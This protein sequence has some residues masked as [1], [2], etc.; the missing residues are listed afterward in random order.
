VSEEDLGKAFCFGNLEADTIGSVAPAGKSVDLSNI[1]TVGDLYALVSAGFAYAEILDRQFEKFSKDPQFQ[2]IFEEYRSG[3]KNYRDSKRHYPND[4]LK[5][6]VSAE[7]YE[8]LL[9][10]LGPLA[11]ENESIRIPSED[12][13]L[14]FR[15]F[16]CKVWLSE[17]FLASFD[18]DNDLTKYG[19]IMFFP[20]LLNAITSRYI[21][22]N[23][24]EVKTVLEQRYKRFYSINVSNLE[25]DFEKLS[26]EKIAKL[27]GNLR[28]SNEIYRLD[29]EDLS[30]VLSEASGRSVNVSIAYGRP[31]KVLGQNYFFSDLSSLRN[32]ALPLNGGSDEWVMMWEHPNSQKIDVDVE[33]IGFGSLMFRTATQ[34]LFREEVAGE[35]E[36]IKIGPYTR[37]L[38][39]GEFF[40]AFNS[41]SGLYK[42]TGGKK[43]V[44]GRFLKD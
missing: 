13:F 39:I 25:G 17:K 20:S 12:T 43:G 26:I 6:L 36:K 9:V 40:E 2:D 1:K 7:N 29:E 14:E 35:L 5:T 15:K 8:E 23:W 28:N 37:N 32:E 16:P 10:N 42:Y 34:M 38:C 4:F 22:G 19:E 44:F 33:S 41:D 31:E 27:I 18:E 30:Q 21:E 11:R 24:A 3:L